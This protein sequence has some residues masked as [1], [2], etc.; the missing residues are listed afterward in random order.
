MRDEPA[1]PRIETG[2]SDRKPDV[3]SLETLPEETE[4]RDKT[5]RVAL[6][7]DEAV[8]VE[9]LETKKKLAAAEEKLALMSLESCRYKMVALSKEEIILINRITNAHNIGPIRDARMAGKF[10]VYELE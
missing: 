4:R 2:A 7:R 1:G 9:L 5:G 8:A 10:L 3:D 6:S